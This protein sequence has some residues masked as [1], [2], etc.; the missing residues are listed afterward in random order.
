MKYVFNI[1]TVVIFG[2]PSLILSY[3]VSAIISGWSTGKYLFN[4]HEDESIKRFVK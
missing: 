3:I 1:I 4:K 2:Y